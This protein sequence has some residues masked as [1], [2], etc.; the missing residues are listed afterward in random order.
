MA[1]GHADGTL[2]ANGEVATE[3]MMDVEHVGDTVAYVAGLPLS[4][5][6]LTVNIMYVDGLGTSYRDAL[7][8]ITQ[9]NAYA[10]CRQRLSGALETKARWKDV[11]CLVNCTDLVNCSS[12]RRHTTRREQ[13]MITGLRASRHWRVGRK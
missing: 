9:G 8:H 12:M 1:S 2:Q 3:H 5:T 6:M 13:N 4:V 7:T 10:V 11:R